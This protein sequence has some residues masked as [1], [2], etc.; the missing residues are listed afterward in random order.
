MSNILKTPLVSAWNFSGN[1]VISGWLVSGTVFEIGASQ[2]RSWDVNHYTE[3]FFYKQRICVLFAHNDSFA[4]DT[5]A[6]CLYF[7]FSEMQ[8]VSHETKYRDDKLWDVCRKNKKKLCLSE[9][10]C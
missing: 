4:T 7:R 5:P 8:T 10:V 1:Q 3:T 6:A 9:N 2:T